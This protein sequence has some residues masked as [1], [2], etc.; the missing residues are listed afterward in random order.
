MCLL[1]TI[2]IQ[3]LLEAHGLISYI[4]W[5][6]FLETFSCQKIITIKPTL[7]LSLESLTYGPLGWRTSIYGV[8]GWRAAAYEAWSNWA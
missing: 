7:V 3:S 4:I 1:L 5:E 2:K 8:F 6:I